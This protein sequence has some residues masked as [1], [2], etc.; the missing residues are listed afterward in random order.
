MSSPPTK[1]HCLGLGGI[2]LRPRPPLVFVHGLWK[3]TERSL[4]LYEISEVI[5][6]L[7]YF[8]LKVT[9]SGEQ[10][11]FDRRVFTDLIR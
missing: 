10:E 7:R 1:P 11:A 8:K 3:V 9:C 5:S 6:I 4:V 2:E